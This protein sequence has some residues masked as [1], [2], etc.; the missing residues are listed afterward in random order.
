L[1]FEG[2]DVVPKRED[3]AVVQ[4]ACDICDSANYATSK[5]RRTVTGRLEI[6]KYCSTCR[7]HTD[8]REKR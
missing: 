7:R 2:S 4:L 8:H 6:K 3:R 5:N 1:Q